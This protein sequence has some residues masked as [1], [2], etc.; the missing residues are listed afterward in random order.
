VVLSLDTGWNFTIACL[1]CLL[2]RGDNRISG[3][4][5]ISVVQSEAEPGPEPGPKPKHILRR[6]V[7]CILQSVAN[8]FSPDEY[9]YGYHSSNLFSQIQIRKVFASFFLTNTN[10]ISIRENILKWIQIIATLR[11][12]V[13]TAGRGV[14]WPCK[15]SSV[16]LLCSRTVGCSAVQCSAVQCSAV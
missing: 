5:G 7:P 4:S 8:T 14:S 12:W 1:T 16:W 9:E 10:M 15:L 3:L 11:C 6:F 13:N 2:C